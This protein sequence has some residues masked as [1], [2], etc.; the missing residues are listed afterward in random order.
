MSSPRCKSC[1]RPVPQNAKFCPHCGAPI[2]SATPAKHRKRRKSGHTLL[3]YGLSAALFM[4]IGITLFIVFG[5]K[6]DPSRQAEAARLRSEL[7]SLNAS[8]DTIPSSTI[9]PDSLA[10]P[11]AASGSPGKPSPSFDSDPSLQ[12]LENEREEAERLVRDARKR[13]EANEQSTTGASGLYTGTICGVPVRLSL[14]QQGDTLSGTYTGNTRQYL[15]SGTIDTDN[16]FKL[17]VFDNGTPEVHL[18]G[19]IVGSK[20]TGIWEEYLT[21]ATYDFKL[22]K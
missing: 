2:S 8:P 7:Q 16:R 19:L 15:V 12:Q 20:M 5:K 11:P 4:L 18:S 17:T 14:T 21:S 9:L 13:A 3:A 6:K 22:S 1:R 10:L